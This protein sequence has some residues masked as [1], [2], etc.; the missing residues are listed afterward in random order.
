[1][2]TPPKF[3]FRILPPMRSEASRITRSF[4]PF[5]AKTFAADIPFRKEKHVIISMEGWRLKRG[6]ILAAAVLTG[7]TSSDD[8]DGGARGRIH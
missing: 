3:S 8:D 2:D 5:L 7:D 4:T 6:E 1:M